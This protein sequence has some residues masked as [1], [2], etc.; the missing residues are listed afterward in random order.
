MPP[1]LILVRDLILSTR[2]TA[3]AKDF[4]IPFKLV[5]NPAQLPGETGRLLI[6]DLNQTW[7]AGTGRRVETRQP[8][9][10]CWFCLACGY[11]HHR[12]ARGRGWIGFWLGAGLW[13]FF[14]SCFGRLLEHRIG[15]RNDFFIAVGE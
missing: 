8:A 5:R 12:P 11:R 4:N 10:R 7:R 1:I 9:G 14:L 13:R 15:H 6:V 2:I 3:A